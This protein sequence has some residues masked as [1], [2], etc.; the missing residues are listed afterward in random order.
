[1]RPALCHLHQTSFSDIRTIW[2]NSFLEQEVVIIL[3]GVFMVLIL[4]SM[5]GFFLSQRTQTDI[6]RE[7]IANLNVRIRSWWWMCAVLTLALVTGSIGSVILFGFISFV[8]LQ[9]FLALTPQHAA[10]QRT[11]LW[12]FLVI[13][14]LQ[15]AL[16]AINWYGLFAILIPVYALLFI[17]IQSILVSNTENF[18]VR[19]AT[20]QWGLMLCVYCISY[21]PALFMLDIAGYEGENLKLIVFLVLI[22]QL[23]DVGQYIFGKTLGRRKIIPHVSPNKTWEG[24]IGGVTLATIVGAALWWMTPFTMWQAGLISIVITLAGFAGGLCMSAIKRDRGV[25]DFGTLIAGHGGMLDR[26]DS[27]CFA[28]PL[29]FHITRYFF[30]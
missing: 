18:M 28:A 12:A 4:S 1:M 25:K 5:V 7:V 20:L 23:S 24:L 9:E 6:G 3:L 11:R 27:I 30:T 26:V 29:F 10:D 2:G 21:I 22:V 19:M 14:P 17:P 15:Y 8:A 13:I 16:I